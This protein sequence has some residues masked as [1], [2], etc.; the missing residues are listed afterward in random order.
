MSDDGYKVDNKHPPREHQFK[1]GQSGNPEG[2]RRHNQELKRLR[3][4]SAEEVSAIATMILEHD[5]KAL[6]ELTKKTDASILQLWFAKIAAKAIDKGDATALSII[7]D[8]VCGKAPSKVEIS[9]KDGGPITTSEM[10]HE[11]RLAEIERL[12]KLRESCGDD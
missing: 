10:T 4:L 7:L 6:V 3:R 8:R 5:R 12:R 1:P 9:G 11:E 2:A